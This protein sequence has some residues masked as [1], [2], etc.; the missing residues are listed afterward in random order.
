MIPQY[1]SCLSLF[2]KFIGI[3][4]CNECGERLN[5][6]KNIETTDIVLEI[7][8]NIG[9]SSLVIAYR[10]SNPSKNLVVVEPS[11][12]AI[13]ELKRNQQRNHLKFNI[14]QGII[15]TKSMYATEYGYNK[16]VKL[17]DTKLSSS[18]DVPAITI[19]EIQTKF[20]IKFNTLVIDCEGCYETL[21]DS[22]FL[23]NFNKIFIEWDGKF[24]EKWLLKN[25]FKKMDQW[26]HLQLIHG[27]SYYRRI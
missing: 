25:G 15:G 9:S 3:N 11:R 4:P 6:L 1:L 23:E 17:S 27:I 12:N 10:I 7:G 16:Y 2:N 20:G 24:L 8:A 22:K 13:E 14:F 26:K 19:E 18:Y 21:F 5:I